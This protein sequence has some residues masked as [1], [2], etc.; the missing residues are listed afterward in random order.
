MSVLIVS[1]LDV[2]GV[3]WGDTNL[4]QN[5]TTSRFGAFKKVAEFDRESL[6]APLAELRE[7]EL[8]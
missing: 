3:G 8:P 1:E 6:A 2:I 4:P 5:S 7:H